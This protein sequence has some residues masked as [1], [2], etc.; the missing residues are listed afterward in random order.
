LIP[1]VKGLSENIRVHSILGRFLEH[2]RIY[3]FH[4]DGQDHVY[5]ASADWMPRN[6][7]Q[8]IE[9]A[10]E[11]TNKNMKKRLIGDLELSLQDNQQRWELNAS[12]EYIRVQ[13]AEGDE[14]INAQK[15]FLE[16]L[17]FSQ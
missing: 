1:Q 17:S 2:G 13:A 14:L 8:R 6:L 16:R 10:V 11:I 12:G 9:Q 15:Q 7:T 3:W 5:C 4:D